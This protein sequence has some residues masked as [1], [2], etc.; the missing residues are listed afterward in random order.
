MV[1]ENWLYRGDVF[2]CKDYGE[3]RCFCCIDINEYPERQ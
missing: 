2:N 1:E 3:T